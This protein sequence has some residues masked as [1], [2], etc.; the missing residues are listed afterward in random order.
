MSGCA[1]LLL[2]PQGGRFLFFFEKQLNV[3]NKSLIRYE[4]P[5]IGTLISECGLLIRIGALLGIEAL[6]CKKK[7]KK[8]GSAYSNG[9]AFR[10]EGIK[11]HH[12]GTPS[13][14]FFM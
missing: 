8:L 13:I 1:Y 14:L 12:Y 4:P 11:L 3:E 2:I 7:K 10:K 9:S 6:I 5:L